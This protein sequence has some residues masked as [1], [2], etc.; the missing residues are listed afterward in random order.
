MKRFVLPLVAL[1]LLSGI[2]AAAPIVSS[3]STGLQELDFTQ[4]LALNKFDPALGTLDT[5]TLEITAKFLQDLKVENIKSTPSTQA[6]VDHQAAVDISFV[7]SGIE[8][9]SVGTNSH[10]NPSLG[11]FDQTYDSAGTSG[12]TYPEVT[13]EKTLTV[14]IDT[15]DFAFFTGAGQIYL[16]LEGVAELLLT[17][18]FSGL[19]FDSL[20]TADVTAKVTYTYTAPVPEPAMLSLLGVGIL[21]FR[22]FK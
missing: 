19:V 21:F 6:N 10:Y 7:G 1:M 2:T 16:Q 4:T 12:I 5:V 9:G 8:V 15:A 3:S 14:N 22:R 13:A 11:A 17:G 18:K 20:T